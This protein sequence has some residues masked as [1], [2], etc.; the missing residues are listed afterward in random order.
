MIER[1]RQL[2]ELC[3]GKDTVM[4]PTELYNEG[5]LL[6]L[7]LDWF[8]RNRGRTKD[9]PL[10]FLPGARWYSEAMIPPPFLAER[11]GDPRAEAF[12]H[13]D[14]V[15]GHFWIQP[16]ERGEAV[17][18]KDARQLVVVEAKLGSGL[19]KGV[20]NAP[21]YDQA[22][23]N[24]ACMA[25]MLER[26]GADPGAMESLGFYVVAPQE[27][28]EAGVFGGLVRKGS[29]RE[30]VAE[31]VAGYEGSKD[32]WFRERFEPVLERIELELLSWE[33]VL[34]CIESTAPSAGLWQFYERCLNVSRVGK[35]RPAQV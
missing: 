29:V 12:T 14:G 7:V 32:G 17:L 1:I 34:A 5:W 4:P 18:E 13:A 30:K 33:S 28:I 22:A 21:G 35:R 8:D 6:R 16:E 24:V 26:A 27:Q 20:T 10:S 23:R 2:L 31:R 11:R 9:H 15:I 25:E 19:S 3:D